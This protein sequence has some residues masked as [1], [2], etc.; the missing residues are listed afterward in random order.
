MFKDLNNTMPAKHRQFATFIT[1]H[2][3][4]LGLSMNQLAKEIGAPRSRIHYWE[5]GEYLPHVEV[6]EPLAQA[7]RVSYEDLFALAGYTHPDALPSP[8][9]YLRAKFPRASK[10]TLAEAER[11][12]TELETQEA[13]RSKKKAE[14]RQ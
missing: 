7:L 4:A 3:K 14:G 12:F 13:K 5:Q 2:R 9:P 11:L 6:L 1:T 8:Q 10:R